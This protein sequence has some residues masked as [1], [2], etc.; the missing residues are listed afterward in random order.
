MFMRRLTKRSRIVLCL[1]TVA[2]AAGIATALVLPASATPS[3]NATTTLLASG[4]INRSSDIL[5]R[6]GTN[7][8]VA[9]NTFAAGGSSGWHSHPG[10]AIV[11]VAQ[12]TVTIYTA[13]R[14]HDDDGQRA[15]ADDKQRGANCDVKTYT[16]GQSFFERPGDVQ[17]GV[18]QGTTEVVVYVMFP[19]VP[20]IGSP[21]DDRPDPGVCPGV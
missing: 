19:S 17:D 14:D 15:A 1:S 4:T 11:V 2:L 3:V 5:F 8:V 13:R 12:G 10:G 21:R 9:K 7:T 18:T 16:Q 20:A 6:E